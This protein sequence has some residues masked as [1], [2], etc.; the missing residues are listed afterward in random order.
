MHMPTPF[1]QDHFHLFLIYTWNVTFLIPHT[2]TLIQYES[3]YK[4]E[5][6]NADVIKL[7][8]GALI[9]KAQ[10]Y[11]PTPSHKLQVKYCKSMYAYKIKN[12]TFKYILEVDESDPVGNGGFMRMWTYVGLY[13]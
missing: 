4:L 2:Y 8:L 11:L 12:V 7:R 13:K 9:H 10:S 3:N 5:S 6:H 1:P